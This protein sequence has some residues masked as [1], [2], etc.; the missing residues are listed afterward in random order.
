MTDALVTHGLTKTYG[1]VPAVD[2]L[3]LR[4]PAGLLYGFLGPNGA[5]KTTTIR[6][7]LGLIH[8]TA[9]SAEVLGQAVAPGRGTAVL[10]RVGAL[11]EEPAA[12]RYLSGRRNL[13]YYA[14][15]AGPR[16]DAR[17][18]LARVDEVLALVDLTAAA[19]KRV[20]AYSQGMRQR[21][22]IARAL[23]GAPDVLVLDEPTNGLDPQGIA[24][25]R[26]LLR[27]LADDGTTVFVS[28][29]LLAEVE[30]MCDRVGVLAHGRLVA[31]GPP[32]NLR[33]AGTRLRVTVDDPSRALAVL[34]ALPGVTAE[35][36]EPPVGAG[37]GP[38]AAPV[39]AGATVNGA[40]TRTGAAAP[41][42]AAAPAPTGAP[43]GGRSAVLRVRLT[44]GTAPR[45]V[46]AALVAAGIAVDELAL[47]HE[48]LEDVFLDLVGGADAPR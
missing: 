43:H 47:E 38:G 21:L 11:V 26:A 19:G 1:G 15:V 31:E 28:S 23:L 48:R 24:E 32:S 36:A 37:R 29:H 41:P 44:D 5:G 12:Y 14:K 2:H 39:P 30:A 40:V 6:M 45:A 17:R 27:R 42:G 13:E 25:I 20:R 4:V 33:P 22:G 46:N 10:R 7:L 16:D 8:P 9:G 35:T 34:A 3:D 18:R